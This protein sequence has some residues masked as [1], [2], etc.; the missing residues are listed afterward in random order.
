MFRKSLAFLPVCA[1]LLLGF[2]APRSNAQSISWASQIGTVQTDANNSLTVHIS[3]N[4]FNPGDPL[5]AATVS[6]SIT[7][8]GILGEAS[9]N[10]GAPVAD[11]TFGTTTLNH[12][13]VKYAALIST[14]F[15]YIDLNTGARTLATMKA[16]I[17]QYGRGILNFQV[18]D[19]HTHVTLAASGTAD[20]QLTAYQVSTGGTS[21]QF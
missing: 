5:Q 16:N 3:V 18:I 9:L 13:T 20:G 11:I 10:V 17:T 7:I 1:A 19:A 2:S 12:H 21:I 4:V 6:G 8:Y 15:Y 14:P